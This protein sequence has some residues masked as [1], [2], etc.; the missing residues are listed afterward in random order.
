MGRR[1]GSRRHRLGYD[2]LQRLLGRLTD[3]AVAHPLA[4]SD[5]DEEHGR[6]R[7]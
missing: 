2:G 1:I 7:G 4:D 3:H 5:R 6:T